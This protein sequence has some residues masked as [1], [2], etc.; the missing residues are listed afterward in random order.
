MKHLYLLAVVLLSFALSAQNT[1][2]APASGDLLIND[3][4]GILYDAGGPDGPYTEDNEAFISINGTEGEI[5]A[6]TFTEF[7]VENFFDDLTIYDGPT[8]DSP[9]VGTFSGPQ[10]PNNGEPILLSG[11]SCLVVFASDFSVN[12]EGFAMNFQCVDFTEPPVAAASYPSLSCTGTVAFAD[13]ST[14]FPTSWTWD[15]GDGNTSTEQNPTHTYAEAG[16]YDI[17]LTACNDN[18]CDTFI[19]SQS[20]TFDPESLACTN[21]ISLIYQGADSTSLCNGT[22]YDN[23]GPDGDYLEGSFD[24]F[25]IAPPGATNITVTFTA[26][27]LGGEANNHDQLTI[28]DASNGFTTLATF[29]GNTLPNNGQPITYE[30]SALFLY[31]FSDHELNFPGFEMIWSANG[32]VNPPS[33][34]FTA[35]TTTV[36]FG[37]AIQFTDTSTENPG[38]WVWDFGD[39]TTSNEQ[40]PSYVYAEAG[41]YEVTLSV[42]NCNGSDTSVPLTITVQEPP[43]ITYDPES[44]L[45]ELDAG[46]STTGILNLCNVGVGGLIT[47][48]SAEDAADQVGYIL[49]FTTSAEGEGFA[50]QMLTPEFEVVAESSQS[51]EANTT[52]TEI[53]SGLE[54]NAQY[55]FTVTGIEEEVS[56]L[57]FLTLTDLGTGTV[58]FSGSA[59]LLPNLFYG[60][61]APL[62]GPGGAPSW[63]TLGENTSPLAAGICEDIEVTFDAT[64]L[65]DGTYEGTIIINTNDPN[66][67]VITI[68]VTLIVNGTPELTISANDL[69]FGEVQVGGISELELT[70]E[71][72]GTAAVEVSGLTSSVAAFAVASANDIVLSPGATQT[73]SVAFAP[74]QVASFA[75]TLTLVNNAGDDE[76]VNLTGAGIAAPSL[77]VNPTE[78]VVELISGES[79]TLTV[80][81][82]N[83]GEAPLE[84]TVGSFSGSTGY[85][86]NFTTDAWGAEFSWNLLNSSGAVVQ[87]SAGITY[88]SNTDYSVEL[89]G[90]SLTETYTLQL[91]DSWGDGALPNYSVVDGLTGL[92]IVEGAFVGNVAEELVELGS[93]TTEFASIT[94]TSGTVQVGENTQLEI[95]IDATNLATGVYT[96][97]YDLNTNDPLQPVATIMVTLFVIAPVTAAIDVTDFV[98]GALPVQFTDASTNVPTSWSWD[99][100]DGTTS[101]EQNPEHTYAASGTYTITLEAC[102]SLGCDEVVLTDFVTVDLECF[103]Q[104]IPEHGNEL[105]TVCEGN[106]F[107]SGGPDAP[108]LEGSFGSVTIAP[109]GATSV[110]ITFSE[111]EFQEHADFLL[112]YD[113][114]PETGTLLGNFTGSDLVGQTLTATS[115][116]LT[117]QEYTDHFVNLSGFVASFACTTVTRPPSPAFTIASDS[118]CSNEPVAFID[119]TTNAPNSWFWEFGDGGTS[120]E[121][122]PFYLYAEGGTYTVNLT[123]CN[124]IGCSTLVQDITITIDTDCVIE[125][126]PVNSRQVIAGCSGSLYDSGGADGNYLDEN[127]GITT[128]YS[129]GGPITLDFV[130]FN[131]EENF[132]F[133]VVYDGDDIDAPLLAFFTGSDLPESITSTGNVI[134]IVES[135]D[136]TNN[137]SGYQIDYSCESLTSALVGTQ[138]LV[139]NQELC[140][141]LRTYS[142]NTNG[143]VD[144]WSWDFGDGHTSN[145]ANPTHEFPHNGAYNV[146]VT[147]CNGTGCET[148]ETMIYSN[149]L[150]PEIDAPDVVAPGQEVQLQ[151]LTPEAT[152]WSWDFGNGETADHAT[153]VTTYTEAGWY[154]IHVHLINMDVHETCDANHTHTILVD[155][156]LTSTEEGELLSFTAFPNPTTGMLNLRGLEDLDGDYEIRLWSAV[157]QLIRI[158]PFTP[159]ISLAN[160]PAG[161]YLLEITDGQQLLG[162]T[163][164]VKE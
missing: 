46:T 60:F 42:T 155:D 138:I 28:Y 1:Y 137:E 54:A 59:G 128:I 24:Q 61:P 78:F 126:T 105:I 161:M 4:N 92:V 14:L 7:D 131:L 142:V 10:L 94:P 153:P 135:T 57:A 75:E 85:V 148:V 36:P 93:P 71:N 162:R 99:F 41:T 44:F 121:Q 45:V 47:S 31:F 89:S 139:A 141:G 130:S 113:G 123:S 102:N 79:T 3:C 9:I 145:E 122:N 152:H 119:Q 101:M 97:V 67:P 8:M 30:A 117:I 74:D 81:V 144:S 109:P 164:I 147:V 163:R 84:F 83:V 20:V 5:L 90:L 143:N 73:I 37:T 25:F 32:S 70:L 33:A 17:E 124:D 107:D 40:N 51:Y 140:D 53:I 35:N 160:L 27:D 91:L 156:N 116:V 66:N 120:N 63:L 48:I 72:T 58:W 150:T 16:T 77:T 134:T 26:F 21:G 129:T 127:N 29:T 19:G 112:V 110:S 149:K 108:Y 136:F 64:D 106:L 13:A 49:E 34:A 100:G 115:G 76:L 157:G 146:A 88:E 80:D 96:L 55:L 114:D 151:G 87:S 68:P 23:G 104:N 2:T 52:Y 98:C 69:D 12:G 11:T 86:F 39:G 50:W 118:L 56:V 6:L 62:G 158:E 65:V 38:G 22:L 103:I 133:L 82:G 111:F 95:A 18:G 132:D 43:A 125:N 15:F 159:T 154:D